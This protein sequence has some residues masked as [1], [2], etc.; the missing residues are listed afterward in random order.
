MKIYISLIAF[1]LFS[2]IV[3]EAKP[4]K[5]ADTKI[6]EIKR[7]LSLN[8][9]KRHYKEF[10]I[11]AGANKG[12][13]K[14]HIIPVIRRKSFYDPLLNKSIGD[15]WLPVGE[16]KL[17]HVGSNVSVARIYKVPGRESLPEVEYP[18]FMVG[19]RIQTKKAKYIKKKSK[20]KTAQLNRKVKR[21]KRGVASVPSQ[22]INNKKYRKSLKQKISF[23]D[24]IRE[25]LAKPTILTDES[26]GGSTSTPS[27]RTE[28]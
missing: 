22:K 7:T 28:N 6:I 24:K 9:D 5:Y 25:E 19:D 27:Y 4:Q 1:I 8:N 20:S 15:L 17:V 16:V 18:T 10:Y 2:T 26:V 11:N 3:C 12:L 21:S 13:K 23:K 14:N